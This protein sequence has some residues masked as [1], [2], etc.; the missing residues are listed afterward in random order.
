MKFIRQSQNHMQITPTYDVCIGV[1]L[2]AIRTL[3]KSSGHSPNDWNLE[4][5]VSGLANKSRYFSG[6][7]EFTEPVKVELTCLVQTLLV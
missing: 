5:Y 4:F 1:R 6:G 3:K 2:Y 7:A